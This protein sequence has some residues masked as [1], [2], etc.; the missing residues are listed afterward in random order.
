VDQPQAG[1]G[2]MGR[3]AAQFAA[4]RVSG[5]AAKRCQQP[6]CHGNVAATQRAARRDGG[7]QQAA[8]RQDPGDLG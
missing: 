1:L 7:Y 5:T 6:G 3:Q 2:E 8:G 4:C